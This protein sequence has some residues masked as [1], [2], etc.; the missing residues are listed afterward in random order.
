MNI[1]LIG[2][3]GHARVIA[4]ILISSGHQVAAKLN[5]KY[6]VLFQEMAAGL[7]RSLK[8]TA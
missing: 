3:S 1:I 7:G 2:D 6:T 5:D 4:E 8:F